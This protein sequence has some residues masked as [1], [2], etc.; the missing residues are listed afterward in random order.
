M[1]AF[2][3][4]ASLTLIVVFMAVLRWPGKPRNVMSAR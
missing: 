3:A 2:I 1:A 4:T